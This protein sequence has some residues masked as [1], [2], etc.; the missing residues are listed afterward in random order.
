M[1]KSNKKK[2]EK[3]SEFSKAKLKLGRAKKSAPNATDT[4]FNVKSINVPAQNVD[5][6]R[7]G[8][9]VTRKNLSFSQLISRLRHYNGAVRKDSVHGL[10]EIFQQ[11]SIE[12]ED[13]MS[14]V[15]ETSGHLIG[16][17]DTAVRR[18]CL[19]TMKSIIS[20]T[21]TDKLEPHVPLLLLHVLSNTTHIFPD[22]R[23]DSIRFLH[24]LLNKAPVS[25]IQELNQT[26]STGRV[27]DAFRAIL[28]IKRQNS[29]EP[30]IGAPSSIALTS[31]TKAEILS[32]LRAFL[33][34]LSTSTL[35]DSSRLPLWY[36][37]NSFDSQESFEA[38]QGC[39]TIS[40]TEAS[41]WGKSGLQLVEDS[42]SF[43]HFPEVL[44]LSHDVSERMVPDPDSTHLSMRP[45][46]YVKDIVD[47]FVPAMTD[48]I[49]EASV[50][51]AS[52]EP[53][54]SDEHV[55]QIL[56]L[57]ISILNLLFSSVLQD[58][59]EIDTSRDHFTLGLE[60][61]LCRLDERFP[62]ASPK[63]AGHQRVGTVLRAS[64]HYYC[65]I[66]ALH[67]LSSPTWPVSK[68]DRLHSVLGY[69]LEWLEDKAPCTGEEYLAMMPVLWY[70]FSAMDIMKDVQPISRVLTRAL[71]SHANSLSLMS[72]VKSLAFDFIGRLILLQG[73]RHFKGCIRF[74]DP[75]LISEWLLGTPRLLWE[76]GTKQVTLTERIWLFLLRAFQQRNCMVI[77]IVNALGRGLIP[78]FLIQH[79]SRGTTLGPCAQLPSPLQRLFCDIATLYSGNLDLQDAVFNFRSVRPN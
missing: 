38:F 31:P 4:S 19:D 27:L 6:Y 43:S 21:S 11:T 29:G 65:Q 7:A 41:F 40:T 56:W 76:L 74:Q 24:L 79:P 71:I 39:L 26:S 32:C 57:S 36:L 23:I 58:S 47:D 50:V 17:E 15:L 14:Q 25:V 53:L 10:K 59:I 49:H 8:D 61:A 77:P 46:D 69:V 13:M 2:R 75:E 1:P 16:D 44:S 30:F 22:I 28:Q 54:A 42:L 67:Y 68:A 45:T 51:A 73:D 20:S 33:R 34:A 48:F 37:R 66:V 64:N 78:F 70:L 3:A 62:F 52:Y 35:D 55:L 63:A 60:K 18:A 9:V 12:N 72:P 5:T